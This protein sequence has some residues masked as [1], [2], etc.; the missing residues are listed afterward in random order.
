MNEDGIFEALW[1]QWPW[2][3]G[4]GAEAQPPLQNG[5]QVHPGNARR[6]AEQKASAVAPAL[7]M[8]ATEPKRA[9]VEAISIPAKR[10]ST[11]TSECKPAAHC[12]WL[13]QAT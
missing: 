12:Q 1:Q 6:I 11:G 8:L 4:E 13:R 2:S 10:T 3:N 7:P 5:A 9:V